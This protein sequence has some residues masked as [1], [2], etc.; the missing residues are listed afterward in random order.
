MMQ[1]EPNVRKSQ[2]VANVVRTALFGCLLSSG[3]M[4]QEGIADAADAAAALGTVVADMQRVAKDMQGQQKVTDEVVEQQSSVLKSLDELIAIANRMPKGNQRKSGSQKQSPKQQP[5]SKSDNEKTQQTREQQT[6]KRSDDQRPQDASDALQNGTATT[7]VGAKSR[8]VLVQE[9]WGHLPA[10]MQRRLMTGSGEKP[11]P[12]Y[13]RLVE[14]YFEA[15]AERRSEPKTRQRPMPTKSG[16]PS[17]N[18]NQK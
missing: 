6:R 4:A 14:K 7:D 5:G 15:I 13:Q 9:I 8:R 12:K 10:A 17:A 1:L 16:K 18:A 3:L 2:L 11:L